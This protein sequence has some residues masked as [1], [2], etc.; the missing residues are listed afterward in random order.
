MP[1]FFLDN[2]DIQFQFNRMDLREVVRLVEDDYTQAQA[3]PT[4]PADYDDAKDNYRRILELVGE[5]AGDFVEPRAAQVDLDGP[6]F[7]DGTVTYAKGTSESLERLARADL[8]GFTLPRRY[9]GLNAPN[10]V[11]MLAIEIISRADA[12]LMNIFGLQEIAETLHSFASDEIKQTYLPRLAAGQATGAMVLTEPDAG[13][14]LQAVRLK[15]SPT[16]DASK[17]LLNG[18]KRFITNG[19]GD[20]LLVLARSEE[21]TVDGRGLSLFLVEKCPHVRVRRIENK[22]GIHGS[23]TCELVFKDAPGLL[24]GQRRRG[25]IRYV[26]ALMNGARLA[27]AAQSVGIAEAAYREALAFARERQQF[28][29]HIL[30]FPAIYDLLASMKMRV[31][32]ARTLTCEAAMAADMERLLA[33]RMEKKLP[34]DD[35]KRLRDEQA[36]WSKLAAALTPMS[37][38]YASEIANGVC[39]DAIQ[40]HGGSGFMK[41]YSV[42]R[43]YRDAR[44]TSI[45]EGPS[46]L[47]VIAAIGGVL[48]GVLDQRFVEFA[49]AG[50]EAPLDGLAAKLT[51][52]ASDLRSAVAF[53]KG[54]NDQKYIDYHARRLVDVATDIYIGYLFLDEARQDNTRRIVARKFINDLAPRARM[55]CAIA[56][57]GDTTITDNYQALLRDKAQ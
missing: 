16:E 43:H 31:M 45:Y 18:V 22:L 19:C 54:R 21:G 55:L 32:A 39:Y 28:G 48:S 35:A 27:I 13:S 11:Y 3:E 14:D 50:F 46:Q 53:V 1:N 42:E 40:V 30:H 34:G 47:Q 25:L 23:P 56:T 7:D 44:I 2:D 57:D 26:M 29:S 8:M 33:R 52:A 37:K 10:T 20:I 49:G 36:R 41:D 51:Q 9:G 24:I 15:A 6:H 4:A 17:W 38:Y 12:A 5:I